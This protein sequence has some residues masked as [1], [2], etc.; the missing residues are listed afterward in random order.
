MGKFDT[1][2]KI[3][4][5]DQ[6]SKERIDA[7]VPRRKYGDSVIQSKV[8][9]KSK[10]GIDPVTTKQG[11][12]NISSEL[13]TQV[14]KDIF[15]EY[16]DEYEYNV[17]DLPPEKNKF[18]YK[19]SE[20]T[21]DELKDIDQDAFAPG[22]VIVR[23]KPRGNRFMSKT[24]EE[25][26]KYIKARRGKYRDG[27]KMLGRDIEESK[28]IT[29]TYKE[30]SSILVNEDNI[31]KNDKLAALKTLKDNKTFHVV[32]VGSSRGFDYI[33]SVEEV[34]SPSLEEAVQRI[35]QGYIKAIKSQPEDESFQGYNERLI[36]DWVFSRVLPEENL[37]YVN[38]GEESGWMI[39]GTSSTFFDKAANYDGKAAKLNEYINEKFF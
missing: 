3:L 28:A 1:L 7:G 6:A 29:K 26:E 27:F 39:L 32:N 20:P 35:E 31:T 10:Y 11:E 13:N 8:G 37:G 19:G 38:E 9:S 30:Y 18:A 16:D 25:D 17:L 34:Q 4:T 21:E 22:G 12:Y 24:S 33:S 5:K 15:D 14:V 2:Y 23:K 36:R